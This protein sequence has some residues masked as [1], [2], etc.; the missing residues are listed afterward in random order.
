M[1]KGYILN[2]D[3]L[4]F[5]RKSLSLSS[6]SPS[7]SSASL[8]GSGSCD[9]PLTTSSVTYSISGLSTNDHLPTPY[10]FSS[11]SILSSS[12]SKYD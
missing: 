2:E 10:S 9:V 3:S 7:S 6:L 4:C 5:C 12:L 11:S 8:S 1:N